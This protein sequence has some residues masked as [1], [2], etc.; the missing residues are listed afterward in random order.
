MQ[1][2]TLGLNHE[3]APVE[4]R[5][6]AAFSPES[7]V[8]ALNDLASSEVASEAT[9]LSTCNRTEIYCGSDRIDQQR[10]VNWFSQYSGFKPQE[11]VSNVYL[12]S[13]EQAVKHAFRVAS[14]LD[15]MVL[16]EPQI[17]GQM[18]A[19][20]QQSLDAGTTG[21]VFNR[22]FQRTFTVAKQVR[23]DTSIGANPVS[24]A[25]AGVNLASKVFASLPEQTV[26][27]IGAGETIELVASR[28]GIIAREMASQP[29]SPASALARSIERLATI[30]FST[31]CSFR[32]LATSSMVSPAPINSTVCSGRLAKTLLARF[33]P[34]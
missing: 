33:T 26:L 32:C 1:L 15:S 9:I 8:P 31:F 12:H 30:M 3:T 28:C 19:A 34:A 29:T 24:V 6:R 14:G 22:L 16:G 27:L 5:E 17:L 20:F 23:T 18:K 21:K 25:Y 11:L 7:M 10:L 13:N 4:L 2:L